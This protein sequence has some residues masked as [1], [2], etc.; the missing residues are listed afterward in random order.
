MG[1]ALSMPTPPDIGDQAKVGGN[2]LGGAAVSAPGQGP[3]PG[4]NSAQP[5]PP[6]AP[7]HQQTVAA[8]RHFDAIE[9]ELKTLLK[10]PDLGKS[11]MRSSII[12]G[13]T[14]LVSDGIF[15]PSQA[16]NQLA[17]LPNDPF[18]QKKWIMQHF[19]TTANAQLGVLAHHQAAFAG[20]NV[21]ETPPAQDDHVETIQGLKAHYP[22]RQRNA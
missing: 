20:Q 7:S 13:M 16:I 17:D 3:S 6:P 18:Q 11:N 5:A 19:A 8:L 21:D 12:D 15:T 2:A 9:T 22:T 4:Q 1:N 14:G 10:N